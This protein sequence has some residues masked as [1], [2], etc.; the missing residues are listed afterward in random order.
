MV[1]CSGTKLHLFVNNWSSGVIFDGFDGQT[2][3]DDL[4]LIG[5]SCERLC[6]MKRTVTRISNSKGHAYK[7]LSSFQ[8]LIHRMHVYNKQTNANILRMQTS[9]PFFEPWE[10]FMNGGIEFHSDTQKIEIFS[11]ILAIHG[12]TKSVRGWRGK[13]S[14]RGSPS[15][16]FARYL[17]YLTGERLGN[18]G[19]GCSWEV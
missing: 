14:A 1:W 2:S 10:R 8:N 11:N 3:L 5:Q 15:L 17:V 4:Y 12:T 9:S 7:T 6:E 16:H 19:R 13:C 18:L